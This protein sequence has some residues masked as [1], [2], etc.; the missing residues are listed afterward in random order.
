MYAAASLSNVLP[1]IIA[2]FRTEWPQVEI[3]VSYAASSILAKQI[4]RG[5]TADIYISASSDWMDQLSEQKLIKAGSR[6]ELLQNELVL[7]T[8]A[9]TPALETA[10]DL[11]NVPIRILALADWRHVPAGIYA[12]QTLEKMGLWA[13]L[14]PKC[15]AALDVRAAL[16][17]VERGEADY[18]I[19]YRTDAAIANGV[20]IAASFPGDMQP[21]IV[22]PV[23]QVISS[24]SPYAAQFI[25]FLISEAASG[26][27]AGSGFQVLAKRSPG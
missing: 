8:S 17:Y 9:G 10:S 13:A 23:A 14:A 11:A 6:N 12:K 18:G 7:V 5:A 25:R 20:R 21:R 15:I 22:Y 19:V 16:A 4:E 2:E 3:K 1:V 24:G 27:F 26:I